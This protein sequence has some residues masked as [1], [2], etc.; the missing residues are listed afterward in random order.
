MTVHQLY[1]G[2]RWTP[3]ASGAEFQTLNPYAGLPWASVP[4]AGIEDV[5]AAVQAAHDAFNGPWGEL[6]GF[7]R[8]AAMRRLARIL[9]RDAEQLA[10]IESTDNG[11]LLREMAAQMQYV[12]AWLDYFAGL[13]DKLQ[14]ETI[15]SDK[16]NFFIYTR[17]EP[18]GVV[19]AIVPWNSPLLLTIWKLA[20]ALAAGCT[21]VLKPSD[22]TPVSALEFAKRVEEAG[23]PPG[24]FNVVTSKDAAT[25]QA[26]VEH[27][28]VDKIAFTGS[29]R[30]GKAIARSA[31]DRLARVTLELGGKSAQLV[32]ADADPEAARNGLVAGIF[33]A[34]G[35]TC[36]AGSRLLVQRAL[37]DELVAGLVERARTIRLG[38]PLE[39]DTEMGPVANQLQYDTVLGFVARAQAEGATLAFGGASDRGGLFVAPTIL[40]DVTPDMEIAREE[41]FGPVLAVMPFDDEDE[42]VEL[43]NATDYGLAAGIWTS[44]VHRAH[45]VA[46]RLRAGTVWVNS[47]RA[48]AP[49]APFGGAGASGWGRENGIEAVREYTHT[50]TI[51]VELAGQ[52]RD[53]FTLG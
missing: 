5:N 12:P 44:N 45:R 51:W 43:A 20:P 25:G 3:A 18:V 17:R 27:P 49:N 29:T 1:I 46:H 38:D 37:H 52:T 21:F 40:T 10:R 19:A 42:A 35:Q 14:G 31:A 34:S 30:V 39:L 33:A 22:H 23:L 47:Y 16:P 36:I 50:K 4:D 7:D 32:F 24:V 53:P 28:L 8:A 2:G 15:P 11:K 26:L 9:E 48:V 6:T 41:V 13:A